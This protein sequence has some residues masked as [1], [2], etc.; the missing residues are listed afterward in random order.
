MEG[1]CALWLHTWD[2][3]MVVLEPSIFCVFHGLWNMDFGQTQALM[4]LAALIISVGIS[5][6]FLLFVYCP[7]CWAKVRVFG[8]G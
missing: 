2:T 8:H 4:I 1:L 6:C 7:T 5:L 3:A